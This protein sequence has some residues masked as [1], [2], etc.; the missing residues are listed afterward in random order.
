MAEGIDEIENAAQM[1]RR[2]LG[3]IQ[4]GRLPANG[5]RELALLRRVE[6]ATAALELAAE[7]L[8]QPKGRG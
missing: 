5:G 6:G 8:R 3:Q 2:V 4:A 1:L 7:M